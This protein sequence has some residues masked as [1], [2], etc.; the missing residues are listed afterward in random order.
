LHTHPHTLNLSL[1]YTPSEGSHT[2]RRV[3]P[4]ARGD[5]F[6]RTLDLEHEVRGRYTVALPL[7][8]RIGRASAEREADGDQD[9]AFHRVSVAAFGWNEAPAFTHGVKGGPIEVIEAG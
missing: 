8:K 5:A 1:S 6:N 2:R 9:P 7:D 3:R 4:R